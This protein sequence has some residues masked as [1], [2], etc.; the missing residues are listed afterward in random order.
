MRPVYE[1]VL[2]LVHAGPGMSLLEVGCG[3]GTALRLAADRGAHVTALDAAPAMVEHA[4]RRVPGAEISIGDLQFLPY[5]DASFDAVLGFNAFQYAADPA[6][7]LREAHRVLRP[8]GMAVAMVWGPAEECD[9]APYLAALGRLLP[10]PPPGAPGPFALSQ[11]GALRS[12]L[13]AAGFEVTLTA[14]AAAAYAYADEETALRGLLSAGPAV[15]AASIAGAEAAR[16][17]TRAAIAPYIRPD[18][19]VH[20]DNVWRFAIGR[21]A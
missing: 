21:R 15:R 3:S 4:R 5:R 18:G 14:D 9:L 10:P 17:A 11:P 1:A 8:G 12:L 13:A 19:S 20:T 6:E 7:A 16:D 2:D